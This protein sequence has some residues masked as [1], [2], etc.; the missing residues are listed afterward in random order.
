MMKSRIGFRWLVSVGLWLVA[1][2]AMGQGASITGTIALHGCEALQSDFE[3]RATSTLAADPTR[4]ASADPPPAV[5]LGQVIEASDDGRSFEFRVDGLVPEQA[6]LLDAKYVGRAC[7]PVFWRGLEIARVRPGDSVAIHGFV[8]RTRTEVLGAAVGRPRARWVG[9][10]HL[11]FSDPAAAV[12]SLRVRSDLP[13]LSSVVVQVSA[14]PFPFGTR[15]AESAC[16]NDSTALRALEFPARPGSQWLELPDIDFNQLLLGPPRRNQQLAGSHNAEPVDASTL[17]MLEQGAPLYVR[18]IAVTLDSDGQLSR[19]CDET[20]DGVAGWVKFAK[21]P[22]AR[23]KRGPAPPP[24]QTLRLYSGLYQGPSIHP[25]PRAGDQYCVR[26]VNDHLIPDAPL[27]WL[28]VFDGSAYDFVTAKNSKWHPGGVIKRGEGLCYGKS[29]SSS[30][31]LSFVGGLVTGFVDTVGDMVNSAAALWESVKKAVINIAAGVISAVGVDCEATCK[32]LLTTGLNIAMAA[33]G[34]PPSLPNMDQLK[35]QGI[36]YVAAQV[37]EQS[38]VPGAGVLAEE[39]LAY[40]VKS[41]EAYAKQG[42]GSGLPDWL[43]MNT[44]FEPAIY[45]MRLERVQTGIDP[46]IKHLTF[47][48]PSQLLVAQSQV[49][50]P[51]AVGLPTRFWTKGTIPLPGAPDLITIPVVLA[52]NLSKVPPLPG[53]SWTHNDYWQAIWDKQHWQAGLVSNPCVPLMESWMA[54][55]PAPSSVTLKFL[56]LQAAP[57]YTLADFNAPLPDPAIRIYCGP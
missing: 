56:G 42:G 9:A 11:D 46:S 24:T 31:M 48:P 55:P 54:L 41:I 38:P 50:R 33:A 51:Q 47:Y 49:F 29:S 27:S 18:T 8:A 6:Y 34:I 37:A 28:A 16:S 19:R 53:P 1:T 5:T 45:T 15:E 25:W 4:D 39:A 36:E 40:A 20:A 57:V 26:A 43:T 13:G 32:A 12:R 14:E 17:K 52:P 35:Q 30:N 10:D 23:L 7:R 21:L 44:G 2:T 22:S 3:V